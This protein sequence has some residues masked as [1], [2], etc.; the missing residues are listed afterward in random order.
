[1]M[2]M[3]Q[4]ST[5][6]SM[7]MMSTS[8]SSS[9]AA[10][11]VRRYVQFS[12]GTYCNAELLFQ[13]SDAGCKARCERTAGCTYYTSD[14]NGLCQLSSS[15]GSISTAADSSAITHEQLREE[16]TQIP[17]WVVRSNAIIG[18]NNAKCG[19][20]AYGDNVLGAC[21]TQADGNSYRYFLCH[22]PGCPSSGVSDAQSCAKKVMEDPLCDKNN[23]NLLNTSSKLECVCWLAS[24][25]GSHESGAMGEE[26]STKSLILLRQRAT[27]V[28]H[29]S[30]VL[31][32]G[33]WQL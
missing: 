32:V 29:A 22:Q 14:R 10:G 12:V 18:G 3:P 20:L 25:V 23:F 8:T 15:C 11:R 21:P 17:I 6:T 27:R 30:C 33:T 16:Q 2:P 19:H 13:G 5:S 4:S 1:L 9:S 31:K 24:S 7:E 26:R 28:C